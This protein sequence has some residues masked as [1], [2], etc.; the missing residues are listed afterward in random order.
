[1][2][3]APPASALSIIRAKAD[4]MYA[5]SC[6]GKDGWA[7]PMTEMVQPPPRFGTG[8]RGRADSNLPISGRRPGRP[9]QVGGSGPRP[10]AAIGRNGKHDTAAHTLQRSQAPSQRSVASTVRQVQ[11]FRRSIPFSG[12]RRVSVSNRATVTPL[13]RCATPASGASPRI[14]HHPPANVDSSQRVS[15][16]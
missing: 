9:V 1:M 8:W 4:D 15:Q 14:R 5:D 16:I 13:S 10:D 3:P 7:F 6:G 12:A 11:R 2:R